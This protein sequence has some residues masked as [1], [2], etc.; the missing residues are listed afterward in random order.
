MPLI[1]QVKALPGRAKQ[2]LV[3]CQG[4]P[5]SA[6][7]TPPFTARLAKVFGKK[8]FGVSGARLIRAERDERS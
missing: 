2:S 3:L 7:A 5:A 4:G 6:P 8:K 1:L